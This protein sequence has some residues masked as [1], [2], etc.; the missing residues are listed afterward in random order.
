MLDAQLRLIGHAEIV[1][2]VHGYHVVHLDAQLVQPVAAGGGAVGGQ[3]LVIQ[4]EEAADGLGIHHQAGAVVHVV[5]V[6]P[7]HVHVVG[8]VLL[9]VVEVDGVAVLHGVPHGAGIV[10]LEAD[11]QVEQIVGGQQSGE[12]LLAGGGGDDMVFN[13]HAGQLA[14]QGGIGSVL[15]VI[16][17]DLVGHQGAGPVG[18]DLVRGGQGQGVRVLFQG[19]APLVHFVLAG[20]ELI[21]AV[22][23]RGSRGGVTAAAGVGRRSRGCG[24]IRGRRCI[25]RGSCSASAAAGEEG[26]DQKHRSQKCQFSLHGFPPS[27]K[28]R[29]G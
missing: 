13:V 15:I 27:I 10:G 24:G 4:A 22:V 2:V 17:V 12:V 14:E 19:N 1:E 16:G 9:V 20:G 18:E 25:R 6:G 8:E 11:H 21:G 5:L 3:A 23:R 7:D 28:C 26:D 29:F